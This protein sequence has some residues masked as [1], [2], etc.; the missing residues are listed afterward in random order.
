MHKSVT[1]STNDP[2]RPIFTVKLEGE[3][4]PDVSTDPRRL[5]FGV[6]DVDAPAERE[7]KA[8]L[9]DGLPGRITSVKS[10]TPSVTASLI[11]GPGR[12]VRIR[13]ATDAAKPGP[14]GGSVILTTDAPGTP[15][16]FIYL[17]GEVA[18]NLSVEPKFLNL[19]A[20]R[21]PE[22]TIRRRPGRKR[23]VRVT[24]VTS[25]HPAV[26][27]SVVEVARGAEYR[28]RA[29]VAEGTARA[30]GMLTVRTDDPRQPEISI[31]FFYNPQRGGRR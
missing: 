12:K 23:A 5:D 15:H 30:Q 19:A 13:V 24:G 25:S 28:I 21:T 9:R 6:I 2:V 31:R 7:V 27:A 17:R 18:G 10:G 1:I 3:I 22:A 14:I 29:T 16:G 8:W 11:G 20:S 26:T 4:V